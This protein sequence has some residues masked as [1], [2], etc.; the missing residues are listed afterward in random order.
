MSNLTEKQTSGV[1]LIRTWLFFMALLVFTMVIVGGAT[2]LTDSGLS[3][4]EWRPLLGAIPPLTDIDWNIA[5]DKYREIPEYKLINKG[6]SL[7]DFK[8]IYWWEWG[9]RFLGRI[10][11]LAFFV[12]FVFFWATG[13]LNK[14][15]IPRLLLLFVL[16]GLQGALG[17]YMVKSG[18]VERTDVS[19]YRLSAHL[20][21]ATIIFAAIVWTGFGFGQ[22]K[23]PF[24]PK[25]PLGLGALALVGLIIAQTA[26]G[27]FVAGLDAGMAYNTWPLMDGQIIPNGLFIIDPA[28]RNFFENTL[29]VQFQHR[30]FAYLIVVVALVQ[31]ARAISET[32]APSVRMSGLAILIAVLAQV[33]FG[34]W[35]LLAHVPI[36]LGLIHQGG[37]LVVLTMCLWHLHAVSVAASSSTYPSSNKT[38]GLN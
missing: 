19:Q 31:T 10:I 34:I 7:D 17:W 36:S 8:F 18:L 6:M 24:A 14:T 12:P 16:G 32:N 21:L 9:H 38:P 27:G 22:A 23:R 25:V 20:S 28:W 37:A 15:Q 2:R 35:T 29:T 33:A 13:R 26:L 1:P 5:F 30:M 11:G 4:T 3:I